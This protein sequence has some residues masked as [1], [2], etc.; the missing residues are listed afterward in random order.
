M[1]PSWLI[2]QKK[3]VQFAYCGNMNPTLC[4]YWANNRI[5]HI[6]FLH[7]SFQIGKKICMKTYRCLFIWR[8]I[9]A[10]GF[11]VEFLCHGSIQQSLGGIQTIN[12]CVPKVFQLINIIYQSFN[13]FHISIFYV[14][15]RKYCSENNN[16]M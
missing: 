2:I 14:L 12:V 15:M 9:T 5:D 7:L 16:I 8:N 10:E 3:F 13:K 11:L 1:V 4:S 6:E